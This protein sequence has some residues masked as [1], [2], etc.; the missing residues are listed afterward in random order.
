MSTAVL[1]DI[2]GNLAALDAVLADAR[3][4]GAERFVLG[5]D[6]ALFGPQPAEALSRLRAL[7]EPA[8]WIRG[9]VDRWTADPGAAPP[10]DV[11]AEAI[12]GTRR[13]VGDADADWLGTLPTDHVEPEVRFSHASPRSD[14]ESFGPE[15]AADEA[16]LLDGHGELL[17]VFGHTHLQFRRPLTGEGETT[18]LNP[19]SVGLPLDG[20]PRAAYAVLELGRDGWRIDLRR[21]EYDVAATVAALRD[22]FA[23]LPWSERSRHRLQTARP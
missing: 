1:Y 3:A 18:L 21:V 2:H 6:Y 9:N 11:L 15:P 14:L 16:K 17:Q 23:D 10:D 19:G 13:A 12:A 22:R 4:A 7:P 8:V 20:D 5:G